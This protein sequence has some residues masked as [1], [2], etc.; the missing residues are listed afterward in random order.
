M[1][2]YE[3]SGGDAGEPVKKSEHEDETIK[4]EMEL[5]LKE[6][7]QMEVVIKESGSIPVSEEWEGII[8]MKKVNQTGIGEVRYFGT[9][10]GVEVLVGC[11]ELALMRVMRQ[12]AQATQKT[13]KAI[14][15]GN[16]IIIEPRDAAIEKER[17]EHGRKIAGLAKELNERREGFPFP[18]INPYSY[19]KLKA[20]EEEFPGYAT[21]IDE[22][23][24][25]FKREGIKVVFGN[26]PESGNVYILPQGSD[27]V[28]NDG[29]LPKHLQVIEGMDRKLKELIL[30]NRN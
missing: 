7:S 5:D 23:V 22:L 21:P 6:L 4:K 20:D 27:D 11:N 25:R 26:D 30:L 13:V 19:Q 9:H 16:E 14:H 8:L 28:I 3:M 18:G 2:K 17:M 15:S 24:Q 29:I 12:I 1:S 10:I